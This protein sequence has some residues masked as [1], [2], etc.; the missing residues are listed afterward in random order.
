[1]DYTRRSSLPDGTGLGDSF[2]LSPDGRRLAFEALDAEGRVALWLRDLGTGEAR[3]LSGTDGGELPFWSPDGR[4]LAFFSEGK[5]RR[6]DPHTG[7]PQVVCDAPTPRGASWG[8]DGRIVLSPSFRTG[9]SIVPASGGTPQPLTTL[10]EARGEKS[11]RFP[12]FLPGGERLL[13]LAQTAEGGTHD[14]ASAIE[15]LDLASGER[16]RLLATN[17]SPL[18]APGGWILYWRDGSLLAQ[19]FDA[20]RLALAG[21]PVAI[22]AG[23]AYNQN[24]QVLASVAGDGTLVYQTG[25]RGLLSNLGWLDRRGIDTDPI[26]DR[27]LF[28]EFA[29][30]HDGKRLAYSLNREGQ[31]STDLWVHDLERGTAQ[32]LTFEEGSEGNPA[33][34]PDDRTLYY[35]NDARNDGVIFRRAVDGSAPPRRSARPPRG[36]GRRTSRPTAAGSWSRRSAP[37]RTRTFCA[38]TSRAARSHRW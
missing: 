32:R 26:R 10:D 35:S 15:V 3:R 30:S 19:R 31:G 11:H 29:L 7:A 2:A 18:Y 14:D 33:W 12:V 20:D 34:S 23:V 25:S 16:T 21:D 37:A 27:E 13:F 4:Q 8:E 38:S 9:L 28:S 17:S 6:L 1:V 24:E 22:A 5:L 36:S